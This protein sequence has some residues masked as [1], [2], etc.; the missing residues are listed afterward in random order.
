MGLSISRSVVESHGGRL[1]AT[2]APASGAIFQFTLP[3]A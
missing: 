1:W 2:G 3:R